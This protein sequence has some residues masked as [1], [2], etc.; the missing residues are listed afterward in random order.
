MEKLR[1][2]VTELNWNT[3]KVHGYW[4]D[5]D[6]Q[7]MIDDSFNKAQFTK[8]LYMI[9]TFI[10]TVK[11]TRNTFSEYLNHSSGMVPFMNLLSVKINQ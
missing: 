9:N 8:D 3:D 5:C 7:L 10:G 2:V 6:E 4:F 1:E 11:Y